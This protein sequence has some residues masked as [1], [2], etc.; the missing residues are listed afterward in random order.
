M[1]GPLAELSGVLKLNDVLA[2]FLSDIQSSHLFGLLCFQHPIELF[3]QPSERD[4]AYPRYLAD[5]TLGP[6]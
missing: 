1:D 5:I 3:Q 2:F 4:F 6:R